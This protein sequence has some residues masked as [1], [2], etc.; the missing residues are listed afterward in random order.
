MRGVELSN[1]E[2]R[3][4]RFE[5]CSLV[6]MVWSPR[7]VNASFGVSITSMHSCML[8]YSQF[9]DISLQGT[10]FDDSVLA[11]S[12]FSDCNISGGSFRGCDLEDAE[13]LRC[14]LAGADFREASG[15]VVDLESCQVK[16]ARF[17]FPEVVGLLRTLDIVID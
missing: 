5:D 3:D 7:S 16:K 13:F 14:N 8:R 11:G 1:C 6:G 2:I 9:R 10:E 4:A 12:T 15:Y 17:S